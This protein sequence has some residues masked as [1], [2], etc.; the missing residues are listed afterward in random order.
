MAALSDTIFAL[1]SGAVPSGV[2]VLRISGP[3]AIEVSS[4]LCNRQLPPPRI[5]GLR[6]L[7]LPEG[8]FLDQGL[9]LVFPGP[10]SFTGEDCVELHLH[11]SRA[12]VAAALDSL[13]GFEGLRM[14]E[15]GEF[16]RRAFQN[17]KLDLVEA[18]GLSDLLAAE[19][20]MQRR[21]AVEQA[22]GH[23]SRI[24][25]GWREKLIFARAMIEAELDFSD[26]GDIPGSVSDRIWSEIEQLTVEMDETIRSQKSGEIIRDGFKIALAGAPNAGKSSLLNALVQRDVAIVTDIAG[27]TRDIL[28]CEL[29]LDGYK[30][31]LFDT[32]GLR[33]TDEVVER[34]GIRRA[35]RVIAEADLVL[36]LVDL[37][38]AGPVDCL[39]GAAVWRV[40]T[41]LDRLSGEASSLG[42]FATFLSSVTGEGLQDLRR[43]IVQEIK[44]RTSTESLA[45]PSRLRQVQ[46]IVSACTHLQ[47]ALCQWE[48]P[49]ELRAEDLRLASD[50]LA[51]LTGRIDTETLLGKIFSEFCV[52]K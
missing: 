6:R 51:R 16:S 37:S 42:G 31:E 39:D 13:A 45:V 28:R 34:E 21:L 3:Q 47:E 8:E 12:V 43:L 35:E 15:P 44:Q 9:V 40:G 17:G 19:T 26:E 32:A 27:T 4:V 49:L 52:G 38:D 7:Y 5:A 18:E 14:A 36:H 25:E 2:A 23:F 10:N 1:S 50:D 46:N 30:V 11:G 20:E 48:K 33:D 29:D 41:K 24:Y 22:N